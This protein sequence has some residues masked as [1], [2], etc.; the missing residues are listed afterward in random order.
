M[1]NDN[2]TTGNYAANTG[3]TKQEMTFRDFVDLFWRLRWWI[4][5]T[6][7]FCLLVTFIWLKMCTPQY[8]QSTWV[9]LNRNDGSNS[10]LNI[11]AE[12]N[13]RTVAKKIDNE[14]F[15]LKSP[16]MMTKVVEEMGL[17]TRYYHYMSP[18][19]NRLGIV[20]KLFDVKQ[21]EYYKDNPFT[22]AIEQDPL[23]PEGKHAAA[24]TITFKHR[25]DSTFTIEKLEVNGIK[26]KPV[27]TDYRYGEGIGIEGCVATIAMEFADIMRT[28]D[29][30]MCDWKLP[31]TTANAF[32]SDLT[33][34]VQGQKTDKSDVIILSMKDSKLQRARDIL[35][36]L[37]L[38]ANNEARDYE[39]LAARRTIEFIDQRLADI[40]KDLGNA[41]NNY[42]QYQSSNAV[43][44][45]GSQSQLTISSDK[46][47]QDQL[48]EVRLQLQVLNMLDNYIGEN[49]DASYNVIPANI[50][51]SDVGLNSIISNYNTM[52]TERNRM[53]ANSSETNPRVLSMNT[54]L[55]DM[56]RT[57]EMSV[58]NLKDVYSI[59][60]KELVRTI[61]AGRSKMA[62]IPQQQYQLQKLG[63]KVEVIEPLY[64]TLQQK[65]EEAQI[66]MYSQADTFRVL[67]T[68]FGSKLPV[69]PQ[70]AKTLLLALLLG[71]MI[72]PVIVWLR[73]QLRS[74]VETKK[75]L[76]DK[77]KCPV[78][79]VLPKAQKDAGKLISQNGRD[80]TSEAF[81][82]LRSSLQYLPDVKVIQVTSSTPGEGKS[83][84]ATNLALSIAHMGKK[85]LIIG[86]DIR[87]PMLAQYFNISKAGVS[88]SLVGYLI[89]KCKSI[90]DMIEKSPQDKHLDIIQA[91]PIPPNP[92]E[93]LAKKETA[94]LLEYFRSKYDQIIIDSAP[95]LPVV[96]ASLVNPYVDTTLYVVRAGYT[97][98][99][100]IAGINEVFTDE[101]HPV[102]NPY[103]ILN[104]LNQQATK[105]R[106]GYGYGYG[107]G[108]NGG[109]Y[110]YGYGYGYGDEGKK[111][112]KAQADEDKLVEE[113]DA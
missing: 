51:I 17:N 103:L 9:M 55:D 30:Y 74:K 96:D 61:S 47:Y 92:S 79:A 12:L 100:M 109:T 104:D 53:V 37:V 20:R 56:K 27:K 35:D 70:K 33:A 5:G 113:D 4:A 112:K 71:I 49:A 43:L 11:L 8:Q 40:E 59:R 77:L 84:V 60:D 1:T 88:N 83:Y 38:R 105:Y 69:S 63:R 85:V 32:V 7:A 14:I 67:E 66:K 22:M 72:P 39:N 81:R 91:G 26:T 52:V 6:A 3:D 54:Q 76:T 62:D 80:A 42:Q 64:L 82:M 23:M 99:K 28:G 101:A 107:Y 75:D 29:T 18:I 21:Y 89:G 87:K 45:L 24:V 86:M 98:L 78:I 41:E 36:A 97:E 90:D 95:Y 10:E 93:L 44:D 34:N 58:N 106:Y 73:M 31:R 94:E 102:K 50:G 13:G 110:G 25:S 108:G 2:T 48:N 111:G 65:R 57:I 15:I 46:Q 68:A 19:A 16:S